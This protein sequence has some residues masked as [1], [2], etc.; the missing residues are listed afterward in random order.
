MIPLEK[1]L[2]LSSP[3]PL[4]KSSSGT[5]GRLPSESEWEYAARR[6]GMQIL[7]ATYPWGNAP[8]TCTYAV[9]FDTVIGSGTGCNMEGVPWAVCSKPIGNTP[10]GLCDMAGNVWEWVQDKWD[11][12]LSNV[13]TDG[14]AQETGEERVHRG[15][16]FGGKALFL[17]NASRNHA[18]PLVPAIT[19]GFRCARD[20]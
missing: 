2:R 10:Q 6:G 16:W 15:G 20:I 19:T 3:D 18:D 11:P 1:A 12:D 13:P 9:M 4:L 5:G 7:V 8:A 14:S 17:K